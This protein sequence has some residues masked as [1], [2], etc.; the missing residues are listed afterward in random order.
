MFHLQGLID[1]ESWGA[2]GPDEVHAIV[3]Y[4]KKLKRRIKKLKQE[5][6]KKGI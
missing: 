6:K 3:R 1:H 2:C 4:V 5:I